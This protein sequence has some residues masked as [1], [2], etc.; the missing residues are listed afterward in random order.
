[1]IVN[2]TSGVIRITIVSDAPHCGVTYDHH[3]DD[4]RGVIYSP[5]VINYVPR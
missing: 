5:R 3:L 1:M 4:S 2:D